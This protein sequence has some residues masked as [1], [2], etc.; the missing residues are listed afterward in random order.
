VSVERK[1][2]KAYRVLVGLSWDDERAEP[3]EVRD[4]IPAKSIP[5]LLEQGCVEEVSDDAG[6]G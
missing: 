5:W 4:D 3:G 6:T 2:K 1:K